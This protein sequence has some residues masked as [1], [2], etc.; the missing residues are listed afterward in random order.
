MSKP[1]KRKEKKADRDKERRSRCQNQSKEKIKKPIEREKE[2]V[3]SKTIKPGL[4]FLKSSLHK[5]RCHE[6]R[7]IV[8]RTPKN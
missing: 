1:V 7:T 2:E 4:S 5:M 8:R 3:V 6:M